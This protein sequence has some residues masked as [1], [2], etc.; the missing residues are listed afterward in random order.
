MGEQTVVQ[1]T[2]GVMPTENASRYLQQLCK[3]W[4]HK[5]AVEFDPARGRVELPSGVA[6]FAAGDMALVV[7]CVVNPGADMAR[8]QQVIADHLGRF[9]FR[10]GPPEMTWGPA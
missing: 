9:A 3:H 2:M 1:K 7:T 5:F 8:L 4:S 6:E 10:E